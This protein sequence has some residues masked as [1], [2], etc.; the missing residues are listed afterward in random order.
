[1][2][3]INF[4]EVS[5]V[6]SALALIGDNFHTLVGGERSRHCAIPAP[7]SKKFKSISTSNDINRSLYRPT[8]VKGNSSNYNC[9]YTRER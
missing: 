8:D 1:M 2:I 4:I 9:N 6:S 7:W 3:I 5:N